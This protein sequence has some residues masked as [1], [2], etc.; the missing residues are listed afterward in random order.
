MSILAIVGEVQVYRWR[1]YRLA[2]LSAIVTVAPVY[3][4]WCLGLPFGIWAIVVL[5]P[6]EFRK[7]K[8]AIT[9]RV[10]IARK[11]RSHFVIVANTS[12]R[13]YGR[14]GLRWEIP[15]VGI[16]KPQTGSIA[17]VLGSVGRRSGALVGPR[18]RQEG[19]GREIY[20]PRR[21]CHRAFVLRFPE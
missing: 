16:T 14:M 18:L 21:G 5:L 10:M 15:R 19:G 2:M 9:L 13:R 3:C 4:L 6:K 8:V 11:T 17:A 1:S 7:S 12:R 20:L